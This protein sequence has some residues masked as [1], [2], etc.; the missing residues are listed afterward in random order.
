[1]S[2]VITQGHNSR[3]VVGEETHCLCLRRKT[4]E[5]VGLFLLE[6]SFPQ[7]FPLG[8]HTSSASPAVLF[9][10]IGPSF[11][12][13]FLQLGLHL[14]LSQAAW[15]SS[16]FVHIIFM[17]FVLNRLFVMFLNQFLSLAL[18]L[19]G[20][21]DDAELE[22]PR[23]PTSCEPAETLIKVTH[24]SW[25]FKIWPLCLSDCRVAR[26]KKDHMQVSAMKKSCVLT[27]RPPPPPT[28]CSC[29]LLPL[30][31]ARSQNQDM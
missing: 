9:K 1:M 8:P 16:S 7:N 29:G 24:C 19:F 15:P 22:N 28:P 6:L 21:V 18:F 30:W 17:R 25:D 27:P 23:A 10:Q 11:P 20:L 3:S 12:R 4:S 31:S 14:D 26:N 13:T 5:S 2:G